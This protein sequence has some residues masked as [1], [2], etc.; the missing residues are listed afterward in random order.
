MDP[1]TKSGYFKDQYLSLA[2]NRYFSLINF[3]S[4]L[5]LTAIT[6]RKNKDINK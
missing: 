1:M 3:K 5:R 6:G 2:C 4:C